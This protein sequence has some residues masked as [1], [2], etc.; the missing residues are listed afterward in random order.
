MACEYVAAEP[1]YT[2]ILKSEAFVDYIRN[3]LPEAAGF[4]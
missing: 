2:S 4:Y 1:D 3:R